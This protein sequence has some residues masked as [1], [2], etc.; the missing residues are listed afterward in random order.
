MAAPPLD[1][2][3]PRSQDDDAVA[4]PGDATGG[5]EL[6]QRRCLSPAPGTTDVVAHGLDNFSFVSEETSRPL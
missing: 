5:G 2:P 6:G 3:D 4:V 1:G